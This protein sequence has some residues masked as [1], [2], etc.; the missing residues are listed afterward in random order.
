MDI[1][2]NLIDLRVLGSLIFLIVV[3]A[4][5]YQIAK[6]A[7]HWEWTSQ[8]D[9]LDIRDERRP[10]ESD[11]EVEKR[12]REENILPFAGAITGL[13]IVLLIPVLI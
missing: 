6:K 5:S 4:I 2:N 12:L 13:I 3:F 10:G 7:V 11:E 1:L 9:G 8:I